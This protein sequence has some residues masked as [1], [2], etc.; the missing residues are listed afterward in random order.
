MDT[1]FLS[2]KE[3]HGL[4][5][6]YLKSTTPSREFSWALSD[7]NPFKRMAYRLILRYVWENATRRPWK[8]PED[9]EE[10]AWSK[11]IA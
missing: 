7:P 6:A 11:G 1:Q 10:N 2:A 9:L 5:Q 4:Q 8:Q 3:I